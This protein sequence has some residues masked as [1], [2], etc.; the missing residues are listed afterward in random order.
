MKWKTTTISEFY[1]VSNTGIVRSVDRYV[2]SKGGSK[3]LVSGRIIKPYIDRD[4]YLR[5]GIHF[6]GKQHVVGIHQLVAEAFIPNPDN[7]PI[8]HHINGDNQDNRVEN[9]EW[10]TVLHNNSEPI[11]RQRK[12]EKAY[13]RK[14]NKKPVEMYSLDGAFLNLFES[15]REAARQTKLFCSSIGKVCNGKQHTAGGFK[16]K[17]QNG[18]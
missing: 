8:V 11:T 15:T 16:F 7:L 6:D 13:N 10:S 17:Y 9:L 1:E 3:R 2:N 18:N 14:D 12:S 5:V 4:G